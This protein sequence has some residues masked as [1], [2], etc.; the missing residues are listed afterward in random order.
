MLFRSHRGSPEQA[1]AVLAWPTG[2]GLADIYESRKLDV[3]ADIFSDRLFDQLREAEGASYTPGVSSSWPTGFESG[4]SFVV[5]AQLRPERIDT[6]FRIARAVA[7]DF[8][9]KP[10]TA[11]E[12]VRALTPMRQSIDR[13]ANGS[14][15]WMANLS[16]SSTDPRKLDTLRTLWSDFARITPEELQVS[17]RRWLV[18]DKSLA[19]IVVPEKK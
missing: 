10:V 14:G 15:L 7:A 17:A 5:T 18:P 11:D 6:F 9:A 1:A 19:M 8:V 13:A 4:G 16:G 2:G 3:L 12:L